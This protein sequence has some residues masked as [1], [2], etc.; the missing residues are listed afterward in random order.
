MVA[1]YV[2]ISYGVFITEAAL[3]IVA[4]FALFIIIRFRKE[5]V[6]TEPIESVDQTPLPLKEIMKIETK[7]DIVSK[8]EE[9]KYE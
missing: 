9:S 2:S 7:D 4:L 6:V 3:F 5:S 8:I 1:V